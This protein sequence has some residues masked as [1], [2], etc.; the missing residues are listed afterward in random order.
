[1]TVTII[2]PTVYKADFQFAEE[3]QIM[4]K[5]MFTRKMI[6]ALTLA[7]GGLGTMTIAQDGTVTAN[8][9]PQS[10]SKDSTL[11]LV[12]TL[13]QKVRVLERLRDV[14]AENNAK[15]K[16][17]TPIVG[18]GADGFSLLSPDKLY[19]LKI[20]YEGHFDGRYFV[21][22]DTFTTTRQPTLNVRR[23]RPIIETKLPG[24]FNF[25]LMFDL[26]YGK[27][28]VPDVYVESSIDP[29]IGIRLGKFKSPFS[30]EVLQSTTANP[31]IEWSLSSQLA[32]NR[33][34]GAQLQG[35]FFTGGLVYALGVFN[36]VA[37]GASLD[38]DWNRNKDVVGRIFTQ[39]FGKID[40]LKGL[41][42]GAAFTYGDHKDSRKWVSGA[43]PVSI[44][45]FKSAGGQESF[46]KFRD[47]TQAIGNENRLSVQGHYYIGSV[48][49]VGEYI[50]T[51]TKISRKTT[52]KDI[53]NS[54]WNVAAL[55][56]LTGEPNSY[57]SIKPFR[58]FN[59][60]QGQWGALELAFR[61]SSISLDSDVF[62]LLAD[63]TKS[64]KRAVDYTGGIN[65]HLTRNLKA[66]LNYTRTYFKGGAG[67][68][69]I[70]REDVLAG[71][72]QIA[73]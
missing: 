63:S 36:G 59:P 67:N 51:T 26:G 71:R 31:F 58:N 30:L 5:S 38:A 25:R 64:A 39:P 72:V 17:T 34:I 69:N 11:A 12:N 32:P 49:L 61:T 55:W 23:I 48:G 70:P 54:G 16:E 45:S 42:I 53:T 2:Q 28:D 6:A 13:D 20:R 46:F 14:D 21:G 65:W 29:R 68:G 9:E 56:A 62:P 22:A 33:D 73:F 41:G 10:V 27:I 57:K 7:M 18:A 44:P 66:L 3:R 8:A 47:T 4:G 43:T 15:V 40:A 35:D 37:D 24:V 50:T 52:E 19:Q 60:L 1:M